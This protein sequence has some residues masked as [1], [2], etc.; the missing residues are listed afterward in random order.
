MEALTITRDSELLK[1]AEGLIREAAALDIDLGRL[2]LGKKIESIK[3]SIEGDISIVFLGNISDGK[4]SIIA[5]CAGRVLDGM[6]IRADES[7]DEV[8][9]Y[10]ELAAQ[11]FVPADTPG[12]FGTKEK[13][14][15][16]EKIRFSE[17]TER[18][19]SEAG[20]VIFVCDA[21]AGAPIKNSCAPLIKK[22]LRDFGLLESTIF[23]LN[24]MD[25]VCR[26]TDPRMFQQMSE[27]KKDALLKTLGNAV[28]DL[29]EEEKLRLRERILCIAADPGAKGLKK[30]WF[31][32]EHRDGYEERSNI[33]ALIDV[34]KGVVSKTDEEKVALKMRQTRGGVRDVFIR[35]REALNEI[36]DPLDDALGKCGKSCEKL[37]EEAGTLKAELE[38]T[39][40]DLKTELEEYRKELDSTLS[41]ANPDTIFSKLTNMFGTKSDN[42]RVEV[43]FS[44]VKD[45]VAERLTGAKKSADEAVTDFTK[46]LCKEFKGQKK[47]LEKAKDECVKRLRELPPFPDSSSDEVVPAEGILKAFDVEDP[48]LGSAGYVIAG[49]SVVAG[50]GTVSAVA[51]GAISAL[52]GTGVGAGVALIAIGGIAVLKHHQNV[53]RKEAAK[54]AVEKCGN[55]LGKWW[56]KVMKFAEGEFYEKIAPNCDKLLEMLEVRKGEIE[57][58]KELVAKRDVFAQKIDAEMAKLG[59]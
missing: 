57:S 28:G 3:K 56:P 48:D 25:T 30:Y 5:G 8:K 17:K 23:V 24:K 35:L 53:K 29:T 16:G 49:I 6:D 58:L 42:D 9:F 26:M 27:I 32:D 45:G 18:F 21:G 20:V 15:G 47:A 10:P 33:G 19:V 59:K 4:T 39:R 52:A 14:E 11:G 34:I 2:G 31:T 22:I 51:T 44:K 40:K 46:K 36:R 37:E 54:K 41:D 12:L 7:T 38:K 50:G 13:D 43:T 55:A 1:K